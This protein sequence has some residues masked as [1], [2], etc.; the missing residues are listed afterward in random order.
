MSVERVNPPE[1]AAPKGF[2]HAVV[3]S[4][5]HVYLAGQTGMDASGAIVGGGI[6]VQFRQ[7][8]SNLLAALA[9]A[10][11]TP[12]RLAQLRVYIVDVEAY[13]A[14]S[15]EIGAVWRELAGSDYPAM[16]GIGVARLWDAEALVE[17]EGVAVL[18]G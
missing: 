7:A 9:A 12:D 1:L 13:R 18:D 16:A 14:A 11:G 5:T 10:G 6:V 8:L 4:G 15:R 2:T 17:V 3:A